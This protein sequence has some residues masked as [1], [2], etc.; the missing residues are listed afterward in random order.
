MGL[1]REVYVFRID[2]DPPAIFWSGFGDLTVPADSVIGGS[3]AVALGAGQLI[4]VPDLTQLVNGTAE[5]LD[6]MLSG[7]SEETIAFAQEEAADV[8]GAR[9]DIGRMD[10]DEAYQQIGDVEWEWNGEARKLSVRSDGSGDQRTRTIA[11]TVSAGDTRRSRAPMNFFTDADQR[12]RSPDDDVFTH[13]ALIN[14]GTSRRW[15]PS[16]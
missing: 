16:S 13:V 12:R 3:P 6:F 11:L 1:Y 2:T 15:G 5:R 14:A 7:V 10:L 8:A 4:S 9:V